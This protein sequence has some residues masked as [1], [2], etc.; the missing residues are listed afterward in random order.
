MSLFL[1]NGGTSYLLWYVA[2]GQGRFENF[3]AIYL[4]FAIYFC[5]GLAAN[6]YWAKI[7]A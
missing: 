3:W 6:N 2:K 4:P 1:D 5:L 7:S